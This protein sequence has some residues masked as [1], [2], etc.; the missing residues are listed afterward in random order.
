MEGSTARGLWPGTGHTWPSV[1]ALQRWHTSLNGKIPSDLPPRT[2]QD[3]A[4]TLTRA[5]WAVALDDCL[6]FSCLIR[7]PLTDPFLDDS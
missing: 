1:A 7:L 5:H 3:I 2:P 6:E 4:A